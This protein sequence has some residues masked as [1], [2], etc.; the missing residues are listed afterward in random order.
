ML[1]LAANPDPD[2]GHGVAAGSAFGE[3]RVT[4]TGVEL[5]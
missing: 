5:L 2:D 3:G 4:K 1:G